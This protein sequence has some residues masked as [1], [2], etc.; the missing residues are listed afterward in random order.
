MIPEIR[1]LYNDSI[2]QGDIYRWLGDKDL[3]KD[4]QDV[5]RFLPKEQTHLLSVLSGH[6]REVF[7]RYMENQICRTDLECQMQ[8]AIGFTM[9]LRIG[10][11]C[12]E[13]TI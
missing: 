8:F 4:Y 5:M 9:G 7:Q 6:D 1:L 2:G 11:Q 13:A 3:I 12:L 10:A